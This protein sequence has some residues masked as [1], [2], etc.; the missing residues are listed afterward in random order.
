[1]VKTEGWTQWLHNKR[2]ESF[3]HSYCQEGECTIRYFS[4]NT[5]TQRHHVSFLEDNRHD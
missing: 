5:D 2:A 3:N 4:V 1:M